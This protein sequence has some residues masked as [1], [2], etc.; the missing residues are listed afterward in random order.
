MREII[1]NQPRMSYY[2]GGAEMLSMD[3]ARF[4]CMKGYKVRIFTIN[5]VLGGMRYSERYLKFKDEFKKKIE[6]TEINLGEKHKD[7]YKTLP[8]EDRYRWNHESIAYSGI[9]SNIVNSL[10]VRMII[11]SYYILDAIGVNSDYIIN[12]LYLCGTPHDI[13]IF[14][15]SFLYSYDKI[16]AITNEVRDYWQQFTRI[17][18]SVISS[19]VDIER[20]RFLGSRGNIAKFLYLGRVIK[21]KGIEDFL[22]LSRLLKNKTREFQFDVAGD[23]PNLEIY[24]KTFGDRV[25]FIGSVEDPEKYFRE[26]DVVIC[27]SEYGEGLQGVILEAMSTG[28]I[29]V[30]T[31]TKINSS[32]LSDGRGIL[33]DY[34]FD[35]LIKGVKQLLSMSNDSL[36]L[37]RINARKI[38]ENKYSWDVKINE[39]IEV[40]G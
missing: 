15:G 21:K 29:V 22:K 32:L 18:I 36:N 23:G 35:E 1:I 9:F 3:H 19:G 14:Q 5:P 24:K 26:S 40:L 33:V 8:G 30:A 7:I 4:L 37:M 12:C 2:V 27:F 34:D 13:D 31:K 16:I 20:F 6:F 11:L 28:C 10:D 38:I 25:K 39:I 17:E